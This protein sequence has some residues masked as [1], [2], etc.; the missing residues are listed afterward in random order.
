L[1]RDSFYAL[2]R[3]ASPGGDGVTWQEYE[4]GLADLHS[5][6]HRGAYRE[7]LMESRV[8]PSLKQGTRIED[9]REEGED[10]DV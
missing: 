2:Q 5:R 4:S 10:L 8:A 3:K 1:L 9:Y 6:V 7:T